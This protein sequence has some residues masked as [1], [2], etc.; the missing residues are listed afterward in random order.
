MSAVLSTILHG[1]FFPSAA[2]HVLQIPPGLCFL[3][4]IKPAWLVLPSAIFCIQIPPVL[5]LH[6][7][8]HHIQTLHNLF[9]PLR[10]QIPPG[11]FFPLPSFMYK[12]HQACSSLCH[13]SYTNPTS[14][15]ASC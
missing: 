3:S 8:C 7:N 6:A 1:L 9:F 4:S 15:C 10:L 13:L 12:S 14:A 11:L 2:F 5:V